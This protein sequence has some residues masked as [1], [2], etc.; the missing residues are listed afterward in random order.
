MAENGPISDP[1]PSELPDD[2]YDR[3]I[4]SEELI[5]AASGSNEATTRLRAI[6]TLLFEVL[7]WPK[8][9]TETEKYSR[10]EGYSDY[11]LMPA[12]QPLAVV[13]AKRDEVYFT[14]AGTKYDDAPRSF[15]FLA[16][17]SRGAEKALRQAH[18]YASE[19]GAPFFA[20]T[21]G[22]QWLL[23]ITFQSGQPLSERSVLVFESLDAIKS[24]FRLLWDTFT[25]AGLESNKLASHLIPARKAPP[26]QKL[27]T[28]IAGYPRPIDRNRHANTIDHVL[29]TYWNETNT[30]DSDRDFLEQCYVRS[31]AH[32]AALDELQEILQQR[33]A[34]DDESVSVTDTS[35]LHEDPGQ[36]TSNRPC[37]ILGRIGHGK[38]TLLQYLKLCSAEEVLRNFI[39]ID[40]NFLDRP[41]ASNEIEEYIFSEIDRQLLEKHEYD[42]TSAAFA[43][44]ALDSELRRWRT[45]PEGSLSEQG[46]LEYDEREARF[47]TR[48]MENKHD[49]Y[50]AAAR[51]L[52]KSL[53]KSVVLY[54]DNLDRRS[55]ESF[56]ETA[57]LKASSIARDWETI[58]LIC[59][60]PGT[61]YRS[62]NRGVLDSVAPTVINVSPPRTKILLRKR[63]KFA[64]MLAAADPEASPRRAA[65]AGKSIAVVSQSAASFFGC[66]AESFYRNAKLRDVFEQLTNGNVRELL[67]SVRQFMTARHL[68]TDKIVRAFDDSGYTIAP[69]E[70]V[71]ALMFHD[72]E[73]YDP[74]RSLIQ[75]VF[76]IRNSNPLQ[77]FAAIFVLDL[78]V[79]MPDTSV[80]HGFCAPGQ[81]IER[82]QQLG[83]SKDDVDSTVHRL[84]QVQLIEDRE[85][86]ELW[87]TVLPAEL[88]ITARGRYHIT[89]LVRTFQYLDAVI[90]DTPIVDESVRSKV[91]DCHLFPDRI[92]RATLVLSY[93]DDCAKGIRSPQAS[94]CWRSI[95]SAIY[96][97]IQRADQSARRNRSRQ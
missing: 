59:L 34:Q 82:L 84:L 12:G 54:F 3:L 33:H 55:N 60:R 32:R 14:L 26:P 5:T 57:Y 27:S 81:V 21:N 79:S 50:S 38:T 35:G 93:L 78:L 67:A 45:S 23:S 11:V 51:H 4:A 53:H 15:Q 73:D 41:Q 20:I 86:Q 70:A 17:E 71:R 68:D 74:A 1:R 37:L 58:V 64:Q 9:W 29:S 66:C 48:R 97:D 25:Q 24:R 75:N 94:E 39:Q 62:R 31:D 42:I 92:A 19:L 2:G 61:Y 83:Y 89:E 46:T 44:A 72:C 88:R 69:H 85:Q 43:R 91:S 56:Q 90:P 76:D 52:K 8:V 10:D 16:A 28:K 36:Y 96:E 95:S 49:Y 7:D 30:R 77:H 80:T 22:H 63:C 47:L 40:I 18:G 13:E 65:A 87:Q 6:D